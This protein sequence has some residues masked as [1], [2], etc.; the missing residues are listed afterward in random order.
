MLEARTAQAQRT[1]EAAHD[2]FMVTLEPVCTT[3]MGA[4]RLCR[5][6]GLDL[7]AYH[8]LLTDLQKRPCLIEL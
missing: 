5:Q 4:G 1:E 7:D 3:A 6:V 8:G 2:D